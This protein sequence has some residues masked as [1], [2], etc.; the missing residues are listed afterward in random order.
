MR[1]GEVVYREQG[2]SGDNA[3]KATNVCRLVKV[4]G[5][6]RA[7]LRSHVG[8]ARRQVLVWE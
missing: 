3:G 1:L 8:L 5:Y 4:A 6:V 7:E 2:T